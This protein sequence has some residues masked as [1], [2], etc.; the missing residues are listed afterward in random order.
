M[1]T[2]SSALLIQPSCAV[3]AQRAVRTVARCPT[4]GSFVPGHTYEEASGTP[5]FLKSPVLVCFPRK[6]WQAQSTSLSSLYLVVT[7]TSC[8]P[9]NLLM[10]PESPD[11]YSI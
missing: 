7:E 3:K 4:S 10:V 11:E 8:V 1:A 6:R 9:W 5:C 2:D